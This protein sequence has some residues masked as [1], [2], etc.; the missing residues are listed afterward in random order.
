MNNLFKIYMNKVDLPNCQHPT[1]DNLTG[2]LLSVSTPHN[3]NGRITVRQRTRAQKENSV[4][5]RPSGSSSWSKGV[6]NFK[7]KKVITKTGNLKIRNIT[8]FFANPAQTPSK[9]ALA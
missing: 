8:A 3:R 9:T 1:G 7:N 4:T 2:P 5:I 6:K